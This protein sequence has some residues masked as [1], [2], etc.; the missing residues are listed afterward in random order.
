MIR[1]VLFLSLGIVLAMAGAGRAGATT[2]TGPSGPDWQHVADH[3]TIPTPTVPVDVATYDNAREHCGGRDALG[4]VI[5]RGGRWTIILQAGAGE[6]ARVVAHELGHVWDFT[7]GS[8]WGRAKVRAI[9]HDP[10]WW[11]AD[12]PRDRNRAEPP[13]ER[14]AEAYALCALPAF[15]RDQLDSTIGEVE[16]LSYSYVATVAQQRRVCDT[17]RFVDRKRGR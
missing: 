1:F 12:G 7:R 3:L 5:T 10:R 11:W 14:F 2:L 6:T 17:V 4:C 8:A 15:Y 16:G 13:A 9:W